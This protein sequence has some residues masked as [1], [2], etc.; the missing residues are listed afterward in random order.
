MRADEGGHQRLF[1]DPLGR[2]P[3]S[4][5]APLPSSSVA[6]AP[7]RER[8]SSETRSRIAKA[9]LELFL[10]Q[11]YAETTIDQIAETAGVSRRSVFLHFQTKDAMLLDHFVVQRHVLIQ[12][13]QE[14]PRSEPVLVSLHL[15][16]R[17]MCYHGYDRRLLAQIRAVLIA[18]PESSGNRLWAGAQAFQRTLVE[19]LKT[20]LAEQESTLEISAMTRMAL[21]WFITATH[22]YLIEDRPSL[23]GCF[24]EV[25]ATCV[26]SGLRY[27]G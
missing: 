18:D 5:T 21:G 8:K 10:R 27:L 17:E 1:D 19:T 4:Q 26:Q 15:V 25:V 22:I 16:L 2:I 12:R 3:R 20:R 13:L 7:V 24:D 9:A 11:G 23:V 14:R 6:E